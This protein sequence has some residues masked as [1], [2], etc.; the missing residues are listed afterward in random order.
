[1]NYNS[2]IALKGLPSMAIGD[3]DY[4]IIQINMASLET[5]TA[6]IQQFRN[7]RNLMIAEYWETYYALNTMQ[8]E[9]IVKTANNASAK[10][11]DFNK[12]YDV[13]QRENK[14]AKDANDTADRLEKVQS[15]YSEDFN[16]NLTDWHTDFLKDLSAAE[17]GAGDMAKLKDPSLWNGLFKGWLDFHRGKAKM[18]K[19]AATQQKA[20]AEELKKSY[21]TDE[22]LVL[23]N[24]DELNDETSKVNSPFLP[25]FLPSF[26]RPPISHTDSNPKP[27]P[28]PF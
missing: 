28:T 21:A 27:Q 8:K 9:F 12:F 18:N 3:F 6:G 14:I 23:T 22:A 10:M 13:Y 4:P 19:K 17:E 7:V 11:K 24:I 20:L 25:S 5:M 2:K 16:G 1:M 26:L 15:D